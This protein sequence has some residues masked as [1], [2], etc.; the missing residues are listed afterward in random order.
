[1]QFLY[2]IVK[3]HLLTRGS[4]CDVIFG[5]KDFHK[6][7]RSSRGRT[8]LSNQRFAPSTP[9]G[10]SPNSLLASNVVSVINNQK[11]FTCD[12]TH[13]SAS[14]V[15]PES[16]PR[17]VFDLVD[18]QDDCLLANH[19]TKQEGEED[20]GSNLAKRPRAGEECQQNWAHATQQF[21]SSLDSLPTS[22]TGVSSSS[23]TIG[24]PQ[25]GHKDGPL[26]TMVTSEM[27][28]NCTSHNK[29]T[30]VESGEKDGETTEYFGKYMVQQ[31]QCIS[32][33]NPTLGV[34]LRKELMDLIFKYELKAFSSS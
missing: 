12:P 3:E 14:S 6:Q 16:L 32:R 7:S 15:E 29:T 20:G 23:I 17:S 9:Q 1:M 25:S 4:P 22:S 10:L 26:Q 24:M 34:Y 18:D 27:V 31:M 28:N 11:H 5:S 19:R 13:S 30:S 2:E 21:L 8:R 33:K